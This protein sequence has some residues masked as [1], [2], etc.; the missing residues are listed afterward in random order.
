MT[1]NIKII[2]RHQCLSII[3]LL[4][5]AGFF[6]NAYADNI[7]LTEPACEPH[8]VFSWPTHNDCLQ[9][10]RGGT[11][12][13]PTVTLDKTPH[14]GWLSLQED[15]IDDFE[16]DRRA[17]IAMAGPYRTSFDFLEV[18]GYTES[19]APDQPY[20]SWGTEYVYIVDNRDDFI[21]LQHIMVMFFEETD[22]A[23]IGPI[24]MK[25]WRQDW[26]YQ[27]RK[28][29]TYAGN[30]TWKT[31]KLSRK[32]RRGTWS[33]AVY[34]VDDSPRY[35]SYGRW[36]H[37]NGFSTWVS[38][39]T[40]RPLPR[41]EYSVRNDY[42]VLEGI[43]RHTITPNG[44]VHEQENYKVV[45]SDKDSMVNH[46]YLS[47]EIGLNRYERIRDHD[48][49]AGDDY[50]KNT[51]AFWGE[52]RHFWKYHISNN[53]HIALKKRINGVSMFMPLFEYASNIKTDNYNPEAAREFIQKTI[54]RYIIEP[55]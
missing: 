7:S 45:L 26:Q 40:W 14:S 43:N 21:S 51:G 32:Q 38:A 37:Y 24:V 6:N 19:F 39:P 52:V 55:Q 50:W 2:Y 34:Q 13:G 8:F 28:L 22:G 53:K 31:T 41:R 36:Q 10:P 1:K 15:N 3:T 4:L 47:K 54:S 35:E 48:F 30:N 33:Q 12:R 18:V 42:H 17:I 23:I 25:H 16:K 20:Q 5:T 44:W 27:K 46:R 49:S 29:L 9:K 11:S